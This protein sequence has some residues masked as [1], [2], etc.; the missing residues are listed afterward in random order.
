MIGNVAFGQNKVISG[1][2]YANCS[3]INASYICENQFIATV[4]PTSETHQDFL[5]MIYRSEARMVIMLTT[6]R[7]KAKI[8]SG[9]SNNVRY[10]PI[11]DEPIMCEPF[12]LTLIDATETNAF[13]KQE[14]SLENTL[15]GKKLSFTQV[16][17]PIWNED[18][19]VTEMSYAVNLLNRILKQLQDDPAK[20]III[21][22]EDGISK[23]GIILTT[24]NCVKEMIFKKTIFIF[25][26]VKNLRRQRTNMVPTLV[27]R[28][29]VY[30]CFIGSVFYTVYSYYTISSY[31]VATEPA[32]P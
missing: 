21:H 15:E 14:I 8:I 32:I 17:S 25:S 12:V 10:W 23:S 22:C 29:L 9:I 30:V 18:S 6:R 27:S 31:R 24:I 2:T 3:Y 11:K 20:S 28:Y 26:A 1:T 19:T 7:E 13:I 16:I 4:H 5:Q